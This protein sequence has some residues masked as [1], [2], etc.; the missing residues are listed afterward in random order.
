[1]NQTKLTP[2][3]DRGVIISP[4]RPKNAFA[5]VDWLTVTTEK[6]A[7][8]I[9]WADI[10]TK[11]ADENGH[12]FTKSWSFWG[13]EG[14]Q[15]DHC[16]YGHRRGTEEYILIV[17]SSP[18]D[19]VWLKICPTARSITRIDLA[20]TSELDAQAPGLCATYYLNV[21]DA[22]RPSKLK[23][24]WIQNSDLGETLYVGSRKSEQFGRVYD[25]GAERKKDPG[26]QY[27]Y[28]VVLR[29]DV[30]PNLVK[31]LLARSLARGSKEA[32]AAQILGFVWDWFDN[33][34]VPPIFDRGG[35]G[36]LQLSTEVT[37]TTQERKL[38]WLNKL[39]APTVKKLI[40]DGKGREVLRALALE[41]FFGEDPKPKVPE[42][43]A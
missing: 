15:T 25:K 5:S 21:L 4:F 17:S 35:A 2:A 23:Y 39:V 38:Q 26:W 22:E 29:K 13:F 10:F 7:V 28:E 16:R 40:A 42:L 27:R 20:V 6:K 41:E 8:G 36:A 33:R 18:A 1:M 14:F 31:S 43:L 30:A 37:L 9:A 19:D 12:S 11:I 3:T 32:L 24:S 34:E